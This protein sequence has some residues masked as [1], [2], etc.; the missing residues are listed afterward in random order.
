M[1]RGH[2]IQVLKNSPVTFSHGSRTVTVDNVECFVVNNSQTQ[3]SIHC[4]NLEI[5]FNDVLAA[6]EFSSCLDSMKKLMLAKA[7]QGLVH[8]D[9]VLFQREPYCLGS[10]PRQQTQPRV[11]IVEEDT[12]HT[13]KPLR[14]IL[15]RD[16]YLGSVCSF[17]PSSFLQ[18]V[19]NGPPYD[20]IE[21][22]FLL[23]K[24]DERGRHVAHRLTWSELLDYKEN[25]GLHR[26]PGVPFVTN[27]STA[28]LR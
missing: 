10:E 12:Q 13:D 21:E 18:Q 28:A 9:K 25:K 24:R 6:E 22:S 23:S 20:L 27:A 7:A 19:Q 15:S 5:V 4:D 14:I 2:R 26:L 3:S 11:I 17:V 1:P 8:G 16:A